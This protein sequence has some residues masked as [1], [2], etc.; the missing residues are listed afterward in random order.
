MAARVDDP[1]R[2]RLRQL[3]LDRKV[4]QTELCKRLTRMTGEEWLIARLGK[5]LNGHIRMRVADLVWIAKAA[6]LSLVDIVREPGRELVADLTD[7]ELAL[8]NA[9]RE[10][11]QF[12]HLLRDMMAVWIKTPEKR[13]PTRQEIKARMKRSEW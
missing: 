1:I 6:D 12:T 4:S 13:K 3:L 10:Q 5:V 8:V 7:T 2:L 9:M 11:P